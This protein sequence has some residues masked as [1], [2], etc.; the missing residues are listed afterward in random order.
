M[1]HV[2]F[3]SATQGTALK[4]I[5]HEAAAMADWLNAWLPFTLS[6]AS[7]CLPFSPNLCRAKGRTIGD[8]LFYE[9]LRG[10]IQEH[11][12]TDLT[13]AELRPRAFPE[14]TR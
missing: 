3:E 4:M 12:G 11:Q 10:A 5:V 8:D 9:V 1:I 2:R 13:A 14:F 6:D 7:G